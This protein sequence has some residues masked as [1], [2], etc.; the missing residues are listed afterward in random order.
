MSD[1][2][3]P[4]GLQHT[5]LLCPSLSIS[6][7]LLKFLSTESVT[8]SNHII[9][10]TFI[11]GPNFPGSCA[12]LFFIALDFTFTTGHSH[13]WASFL[14]WPSCFTVS[15]AIS[16]CPLLFPSSIMDT[17]Q[18]GGSS[19]SV[20]SFCL[21]ILFMGF[22]QQEFWIGLPFPPP[23]DHVLWELSTMTCPSWV[24]LHSMAHSFPGFHKPLRHNKAVIHEG[25]VTQTS[26][27]TKSSEL[28]LGT[29]LLQ[30]MSFDQLLL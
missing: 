14:P 3:W 2:L 19:S 10:F 25:E 4:R 9:Q 20:T 22:S 27:N 24:A 17:F 13:K 28:G 18:L 29:G 6:Q 1:S 12:I 8:L 26:H 11:H 16:N 30:V 5:R 7:S 15:G 23:L 21:F